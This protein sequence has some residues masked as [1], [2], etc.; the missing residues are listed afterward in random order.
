MVA[1][2]L[3][4]MGRATPMLRCLGEEETELVLLE[5]HEG[6]CGSH[7]GG[8]SLAAKLLRSGY[9]WPTMLHDCV[10]FVKKCDKCQRFSDKKHAQPTSSPLCFHLGLSINGEWIS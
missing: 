8:R 2:K 9:Y 7:I 10:A 6:V 3:Y 1:D 4:K 5:V